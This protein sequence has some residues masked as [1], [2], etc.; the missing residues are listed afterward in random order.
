MTLP[1]AVRL[2]AV[3]L[4]PLVLAVAGATHPMDL[5]AAT[6]H[7]WLVMHVLLVPV[8]PLLG[9]A[10]WVLLVEG[11]LMSLLNAPSLGKWLPSAAAKA[12]AWAS[13]MTRAPPGRSPA[14]PGRSRPS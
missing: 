13:V 4:P 1:R 10:V 2:A 6:A 3:T 11:L 12:K 7:H 5:T 14:P 9:V 8:F